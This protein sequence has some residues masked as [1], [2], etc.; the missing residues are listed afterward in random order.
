MTSTPN[1]P[2]AEPES[3][4][5]ANAGD[6]D[7]HGVILAVLIILFFIFASLFTDWLWYQQVGYLERSHDAV[8]HASS[9]CS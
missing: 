4:G 6:A 5:D 7:D 8:D 9:A 3:A 1:R 2:A